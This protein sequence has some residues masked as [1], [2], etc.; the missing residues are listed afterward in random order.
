MAT[1]NSWYLWATHTAKSYFCNGCAWPMLKFEGVQLQKL[2][3]CL[4]WFNF[5][6]SPLGTN[7]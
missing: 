7:R 6:F 2:I 5:G 1:H 4:C 3:I